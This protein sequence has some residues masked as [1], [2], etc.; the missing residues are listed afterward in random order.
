MTETGNVAQG[1]EKIDY[2]VDYLSACRSRDK[3]LK[4][5]FPVAIEHWGITPYY[6]MGFIRRER[7]GRY[8]QLFSF[9]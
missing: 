2:L 1:A 4:Y 5:A 6:G 7:I 8:A 3:V 9:G